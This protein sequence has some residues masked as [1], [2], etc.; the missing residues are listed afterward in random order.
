MELYVGGYVSF[1]WEELKNSTWLVSVDIGNDYGRG[2]AR[3]SFA[4]IEEARAWM[5]KH[6]EE[7]VEQ[8]IA[9]PT[10]E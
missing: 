9:E 2:G 3:Y 10:K 8:S 4:T 6:L 7:R 5:K 1:R